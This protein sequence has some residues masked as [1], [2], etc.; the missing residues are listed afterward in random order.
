MPYVNIRRRSKRAHMRM[1][2]P[3]LERAT[4]A[5]MTSNRRGAARLTT[6]SVTTSPWVGSCPIRWWTM[7]STILRVHLHAT[8]AATTTTTT[9]THFIARPTQSQSAQRL[10]R[11]FYRYYA[12]AALS[13]WSNVQLIRTDRNSSKRSLFSK[14]SW[15]K[16]K[17]VQ[18]RHYQHNYMQTRPSQQLRRHRLFRI[19]TR[20]FK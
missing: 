5:F 14:L 6:H 11:L 3:A 1:A 12:A 13:T 10:H 7:H 17:T 2:R 4:V 18:Q 19:L 20:H 8:S 9:T 15:F 16:I